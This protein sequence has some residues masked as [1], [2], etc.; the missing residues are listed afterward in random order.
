VN[1][2]IASMGTVLVIVVLAWLV[3]RAHERMAEADARWRRSRQYT[4][5]QLRGNDDERLR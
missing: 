4:Q 3:V 1:T 2:V 5:Q